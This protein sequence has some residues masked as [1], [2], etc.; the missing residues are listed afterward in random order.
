MEQNPKERIIFDESVYD[1]DYLRDYLRNDYDMYADELEVPFDKYVE[2]RQEEGVLYDLMQQ[3]YSDEMASLSDFFSPSGGNP[4]AVR[5]TIGRWDGTRSGITVYDSFDKVLDTSP[6]R[7][8]LDNVFADCEI[9]KVWDE[10]GHLFMHGAHHDGSVT[11]E[12]RQLTDAGA[13]AY[14]TISDA[15]VGEAFT[16]VGKTYDGSEQAVWQ[17]MNDLWNDPG[18]CP[19]PRYME[20]AYGCPAEEWEPPKASEG[21]EA[22]T[23]TMPL[24]LSAMAAESRAASQAL[25]GDGTHDAHMPDAR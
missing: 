25:A 10:N 18:L 2:Y 23:M 14:E 8:G 22:G 9:Q 4:I 7:H 6:S 12:V 24:S 17:A 19:A 3:D 21:H 15:W 16:V 5:G 11:V 13:E 1:V 20:Q